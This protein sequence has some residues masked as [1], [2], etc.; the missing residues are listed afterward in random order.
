MPPKKKPR[1]SLTSNPL[2]EALHDW[3]V[4]VHDLR[5]Y[6]RPEDLPMP[7]VAME[8]PVL[9]GGT[10]LSVAARAWDAPDSWLMAKSREVV[11]RAGILEESANLSDFG[12]KYV[13]LSEALWIL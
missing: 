3:I 9:H 13:K 8:M 4:K 12:T 7:D 1:K 5:H 2:Q 10:F 11:Q 6:H